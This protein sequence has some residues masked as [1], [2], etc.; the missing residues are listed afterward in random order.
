MTLERRPGIRCY[1]VEG[2][3]PGLGEL[4]GDK[5]ARAARRTASR[6]RQA[7]GEL[8][9]LGVL[10]I[11]GD[12]VAFCLFTA[13]SGAAL[14][15]AARRAGLPVDRVVAAVEMLEPPDS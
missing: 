7:D 3:W 8:H 5:A 14:D 10:L 12:E 13:P 15:E 4:D 2:Y 6:M 11:P 9:Y 1:L